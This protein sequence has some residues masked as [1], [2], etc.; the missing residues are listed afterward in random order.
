MGVLRNLSWWQRTTGPRPPA[1]GGSSDLTLDAKEA[2]WR[3]FILVGGR[4]FRS[5]V[6]RLQS[7][8]G[9]AFAGLGCAIQMW[10]IQ[11]EFETPPRCSLKAVCA[12]RTSLWLA[13]LLTSVVV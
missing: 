2:R 13:V 5:H 12:A 1:L 4:V 9:L 7:P 11:K 8:H 3:C 10:D 6:I